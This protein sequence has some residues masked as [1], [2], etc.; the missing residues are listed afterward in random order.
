VKL[1]HKHACLEWDLNPRPQYSRE[2]RQVHALD[3]A[4]TVIGRRNI[5]FI[6]HVKY[7]GVIFDKGITRRLHIEMIEAKASE[8]L[9]EST[10]YSEVSV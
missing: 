10:L 9:L 7:L 6:N 3:S 4:A 8:Y 1:T 2:L 5:P